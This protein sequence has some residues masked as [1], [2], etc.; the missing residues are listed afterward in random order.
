MAVPPVPNMK[1]TVD[2]IIRNGQVRL[3]ALKGMSPAKFDTK[4]PST[5]P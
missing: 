5:T 1:P 2:I 3:T 4:N